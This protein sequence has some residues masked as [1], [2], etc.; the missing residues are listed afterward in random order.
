[1]EKLPYQEKESIILLVYK[2]EELSRNINLSNSLNI[3]SNIII[4][5]RLSTYIVIGDH[6]CGFQLNIL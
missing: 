3:L 5:S 6:Q 2:K 4:I 1:M